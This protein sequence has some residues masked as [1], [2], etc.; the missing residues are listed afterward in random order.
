MQLQLEKII[1]RRRTALSTPVVLHPG[2]DTHGN[3]FCV[4]RRKRKRR[5][6]GRE[7]IERE[8]INE[9]VVADTTKTRVTKTKTGGR[10]KLNHESNLFFCKQ[11]SGTSFLPMVKG[12]QKDWMFRANAKHST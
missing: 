12:E 11:Q 6:K 9:A 7:I 5:K 3:A 2:V 8:R 10:D 4:G 1:P